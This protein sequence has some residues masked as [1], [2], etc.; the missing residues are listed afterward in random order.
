MERALPTDVDGIPLV[1]REVARPQFSQKF[2][3]ECRKVKL[4]SNHFDFQTRGGEGIQLT[5][6]DIKFIPPL[7]AD[8]R[9]LRLE[10][11]AATKSELRATF[12]RYI[13]SADSLY[14][15][16][17]PPQDILILK[18]H[19]KIAVEAHYSGRIHLIADLN[20]RG[21]NRQELLKIIDHAIH[22]MFLQLGLKRFGKRTPL[23]FNQAES[24]SFSIMNEKFLLQI[25][26]GVGATFGIYSGD[27][28][29]LMFYQN[30]AVVRKYDMLQEYEYFKEQGLEHKE[31]LDKYII[32]FTFAANYGNSRTYI[33]DGVD[34]TKTP[35]S[36]FCDNSFPNFVEYYKKQYG[37]KIHNV[38]QFLAFSLQRQKVMSAGKMTSVEKRIYLVPE[39]L[40]PTGLTEEIIKH[41][42][43]MKDIHKVTNMSPNDRY[44]KMMNT[45]KSL[46][47][48]S[49]KKPVAGGK[50]EPA[51]DSIDMKVVLDSNKLDGYELEPPSIMVGRR[52][53]LTKRQDTAFPKFNHEIYDK[54][55]KIA[56]LVIIHTRGLRVEVDDLADNLRIEAKNHKI[57]LDDK[58][59]FKQLDDRKFMKAELI[60]D[61]IRQF[62]KA[63]AFMI[64]LP[65]PNIDQVYRQ[66]KTF[67][68]TD[69]IVTQFFKNTPKAN[70]SAVASKL[71]LQLAVKLGN[72]PWRVEL[73]KE[74]QDLNVMMIGADVF[75]RNMH[76]SM[77]SVCSISHDPSSQNGMDSFFSQTAVVNRKGD[78]IF[79]N[80]PKFV[81]DSVQT[82]SKLDL[83]IIFRDGVDEGK[84]D[85]VREKEIQPILKKLHELKPHEERGARPPKLIFILVVKRVADRFFKPS[86]FGGKGASEQMVNPSAGTFITDQV[87]QDGRF[88]FFAIT[89]HSGG[90][91]Q[92]AVKP[93]YYNVMYN[94][95]GL[96][97][98]TILNMVNGE[99]YNYY[100]W[101]GPIKIPGVLMYAQ[102]NGLFEGALQ[103]TTKPT[104]AAG[105]GSEKLK[106]GKIF[107]L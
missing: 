53:R 24:K 71:L 55:C 37:M 54:S 61:I 50:A 65:K 38:S 41:P 7:P 15:F 6:W 82:N 101:F 57:N 88:D 36:A 83:V 39:L 14:T 5:M 13:E 3:K 47:N 93:V 34:E 87:T 75:H 28:P 4:Y 59:E 45:L 11:L 17:R 64:V 80:L 10:V 72:Q 89:P 86:Q 2:Q 35:L 74:M 22:K 30:C 49:A 29:K 77:A 42:G 95:S 73:P 40:L 18:G 51:D 27:R 102:K 67:C 12:G 21:V 52:Q 91:S 19:P 78:D 85:Q 84:F 97:Q 44:A 105:S 48:L 23:F 92:V 94:D 46:N 60:T 56:K 66:V 69:S 58:P 20:K 26:Q 9:E 104:K 76:T 103:H 106:K 81:S 25:H 96:S 31:I 98:D 90:K 99:T 100:N 107:F 32:G 68:K 1:R 79:D 16:Q 70:D 8:S 63:T 62:D 33:I 43:A